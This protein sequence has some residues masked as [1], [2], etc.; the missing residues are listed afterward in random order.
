MEITVIHGGKHKGS[1]YNI[2]QQILEHLCDIDT[3]V[4]E[5]FMPSDMPNFCT[6]CASM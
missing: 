2:T 6:G 4:N 1:T 5:F 3:A